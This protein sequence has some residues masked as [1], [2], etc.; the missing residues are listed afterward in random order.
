MMLVL[1]D[2]EIHRNRFFL[3]DRETGGNRAQG[4]YLRNFE[5]IRL[6][7]NHLAELAKGAGIP[8]IPA[9]NL[10]SAIE[11]GLEVIVERLQEVYFEVVQG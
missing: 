1:E 7:Q 10:D 2:E 9:A 6:I 4:G 3:R 5:Q 8:I 11:K